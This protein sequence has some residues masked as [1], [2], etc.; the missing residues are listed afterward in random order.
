MKSFIALVMLATSMLLVRQPAKSYSIA[1]NGIGA[2]SIIIAFLQEVYE[3]QDDASKIAR[4]YI[5]FEDSPDSPSEFSPDKRYE[6]A[7]AHITLL[8]KGEGVCSFSP[9][10]NKKEIASLWIV[11]YTSLVRTADNELLDF[12]LDASHSQGLYVALKNDVAWKYF[13]VKDDKIYSF[14]YLLKGEGGPT[15]LFSY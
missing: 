1:R 6:I 8:R 9:P 7:A 15:Y 11:P 2:K 5:R 12:G 14:D 4:Q 3:T 10:L 13:Y